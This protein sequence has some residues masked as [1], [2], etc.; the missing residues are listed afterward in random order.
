[1]H[2]NVD[3]CKY[4]VTRHLIYVVLAQYTLWANFLT[5]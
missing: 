3:L 1:M 2:L 5:I 4:L